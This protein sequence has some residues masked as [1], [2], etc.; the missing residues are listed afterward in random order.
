MVDPI[1]LFGSYLGGSLAD[2]VTAVALDKSG[3]NLFIVGFTNTSDLTAT[4]N[5]Y[6][7]SNAG[8]TDM[9]LAVIDTQQ[10]QL[11]YLSYLGGTNLEKALSV[12]VDSNGF[13]WICGTTTS[14]DFPIVG[15][16]I[17]TTGAATVVSG[18]VVGIDRN[19][20]TSGLVFSSYLGGTTGDTSAN[21]IAV[22]SKGYLY[23]AG[24]TQTTDFPITGSAYANVVFGTQ[25]A[26]LAVLNPNDSNAVPVYAT[27]FGAEDL[28]DGIGVALTPSGKVYLVM[29]TNGL[30][31]PLAGN[32]FSASSFGY[33]DVAV[34]LFDITKT[35]TES[36]LYSSYL[37]GSANDLAKGVAIDPSGNLLITGYTLSSDFP[38]TSDA[39][40]GGNNGNGDAFI[41]AVNAE[42]GPFLVY[43]T[44]LGGNDGE[45]GYAIASDANGLIY[46]TGYTM[47]SDFPVTSNAVQPGWGFGID[48]FY[49]ILKRG[50][51]GFR[52]AAAIHLSGRR[53]HQRR[54]GDRSRCA[55][56]R[57]PRRLR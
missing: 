18:F 17:Q 10:Y 15:N 51:S 47:S 30:Q 28:D 55:W 1:V 13:A 7:T 36:L 19:S 5:A 40:Q 31:L 39:L 26:F 48:A 52:S 46:V 11:S 16:A 6:N 9:F 23:I 29:N 56:R 24:T 54:S 50:V 44:Y 4:T 21:S 8:L 27:Y 38:T 35:N 25:D 33:Q 37:G 41:T 3:S 57:L 2:E 42:K 45:V 49:V 14:T 22:D 32:S 12:A 20:G 34:A 43:S 53:K